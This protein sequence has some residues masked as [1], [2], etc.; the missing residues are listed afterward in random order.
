M[1]IYF[2][3]FFFWNLF[4]GIEFRFDNKNIKLKHIPKRYLLAIVR[5]SICKT[6]LKDESRFEI[7]NILVFLPFFFKILK[8]S[9]PFTVPLTPYFI[10]NIVTTLNVI[11]GKSSFNIR[12]L[13]SASKYFLEI[14]LKS[15]R[16]VN[17]RTMCGK[18]YKNVFVIL[19]L[20]YN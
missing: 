1:K 11:N 9:S 16:E 7:F 17:V 2:S 19:F 4:T 14:R 5:S 20:R 13:T 12:R 10:V 3:V 8:L 15:V 6:I 18:I